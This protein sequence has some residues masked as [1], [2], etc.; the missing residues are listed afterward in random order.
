LGFAPTTIM[1][2]LPEERGPD[3]AER[4]QAVAEAALAALGTL[5]AETPE[6]DKNGHSQIRWPR[7][8][9]RIEGRGH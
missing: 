9:G 3:D 5:E 1:R 4:P 2:I 7:D 8:S 6:Q